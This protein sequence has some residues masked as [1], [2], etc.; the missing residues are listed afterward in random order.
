MDITIDLVTEKLND[1][2]LIFTNLVQFDSHYGHRRDVEGYAN[3]INLFDIKL[4][5]LINVLDENDLLIIT[6][7]HGNDLTFKGDNHTREV[8][9]ATIYSKA[10]K[11]PKKLND[12]NS[13]A[14]LGNIIA[15]N[16]DLEISE[17][18]DD[19]FDQLVYFN[20]KKSSLSKKDKEDF[21]KC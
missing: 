11:K 4:A 18:D 2:K 14:T 12:L 3:N 8:L 10:F 5:K 20:N 17:I 1:K 15:R 6:S 16:F 9:L 7:D 13:L 21:I 19:I